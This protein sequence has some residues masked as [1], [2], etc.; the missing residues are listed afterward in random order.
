[1]RGSEN[2]G[3]NESI[4]LLCYSGVGK[5]EKN[6]RTAA[7]VRQQAKQLMAACSHVNIA[8]VTAALKIGVDLRNA[9]VVSFH[10]LID[11]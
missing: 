7:L 4:F 11:E 6:I 5:L 9:L 8:M 3:K 10:L 1:M 2:L